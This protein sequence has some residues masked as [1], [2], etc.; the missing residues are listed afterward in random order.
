MVS[1]IPHCP[2]IHTYSH[3]QQFSKINCVNSPPPLVSENDRRCLVATRSHLWSASALASIC[4]SQLLTARRR[5]SGRFI[6][7]RNAL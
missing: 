7:R 4:Y 5:Y 3:T 1:R 2:E 6:L